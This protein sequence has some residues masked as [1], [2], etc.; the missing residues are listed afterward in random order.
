MKALIAFLPS[1]WKCE[2]RAQGIE[3]GRGSFHFCFGEEST[4]QS[5]LDNR[6]YH[7]DGW[8]IAIERWVPTVRSDF[9]STI[10]FWVK[11]MDLP[12]QYREDDQVESIGK[13][14][15]MVR[16]WKIVA[17]YPMV[18]VEVSCDASLILYRETRSD[19]GEIFR[20]NFDYLKLQNYCKRCLRMSHETR[21]CSDWI[22]RQPSRQVPNVRRPEA[23]DRKRQ[24]GHKAEMARPKA[25]REDRSKRDWDKTADMAS[26]SKPKLICWDLMTELGE[27]RDLKVEK[28]VDKPSTQEW[29]RKSFG[30]DA[31]KSVTIDTRPET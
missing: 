23:D 24:R 12:A 27:V 3:M 14:L 13:D 17:P 28:K 10:P 31:T 11:I 8:M 6:P 29:V 2:C 18:R 26:S 19:T 20:I 21:A 5:I 7:F 1:V 22:E 15:G 9:P 4:L 25:P 30:R 16:N